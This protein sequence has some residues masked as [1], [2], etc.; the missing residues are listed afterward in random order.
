MYMYKYTYIY[1]YTY[2]L[3]NSSAEIFI[4]KN[5]FCDSTNQ[6]ILTW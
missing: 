1:T 5:V 4:L 6:F 2:T 3:V